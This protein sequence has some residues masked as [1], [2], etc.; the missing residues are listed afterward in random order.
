MVA[1]AISERFFERKVLLAHTLKLDENGR[2]YQ[3]KGYLLSL[4]A[5]LVLL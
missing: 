5:R 3:L 4:D 2:S 1:T